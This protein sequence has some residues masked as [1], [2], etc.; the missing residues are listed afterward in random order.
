MTGR[1]A[2]SIGANDVE[3][4]V[5]LDVD[6]ASVGE[7]DLHLVIALF[8]VDLGLGD[9]A[10]AQVLQSCGRRALEIGTGDRHINV[11]WPVDVVGSV[12]V[13]IRRRQGSGFS[14]LC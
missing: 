7:C 6:L 2:F 9:S 5:K 10:L 4:F 8:V 3:G 1:W 14:R 11:I 13:G 12:V